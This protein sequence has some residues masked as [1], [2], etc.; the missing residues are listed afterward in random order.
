MSSWDTR[1]LFHVVVDNDEISTRIIRYLTS[2]K[3]GR[4]TFIPLN[5]IRPSRVNYPTGP[6]V[7]PLLKKLKY[8][9]RFGPAF[10]QVSVLHDPFCV[11]HYAIAIAF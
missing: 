7:V 8:D 5:Q 4:V 1:S 11:Y 6:D 2:E 10:A 9:T 3:G